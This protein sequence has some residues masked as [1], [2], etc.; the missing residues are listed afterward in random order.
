MERERG[1]SPETRFCARGGAGRNP[2]SAPH[3]LWDPEQGK[4][5]P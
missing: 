5:L 2:G 1:W 3:E 4:L